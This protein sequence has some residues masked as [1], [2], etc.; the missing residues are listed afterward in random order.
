[1]SRI[2]YISMSVNKRSYAEL[3]KWLKILKKLCVYASWSQLFLDPK[4]INFNKKQHLNLAERGFSGKSRKVC[5]YNKEDLTYSTCGI[6]EM[7]NAN[8]NVVNLFFSSHSNFCLSL[9]Y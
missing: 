7:E 3:F 1:M 5:H 4:L 2:K 8:E 6:K 9:H